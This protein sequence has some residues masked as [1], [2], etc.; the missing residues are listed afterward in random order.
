VI[1]ARKKM[2]S[3]WGEGAA[4]GEG[5]EVDGQRW[6]YGIVLLLLFLVVEI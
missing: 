6:T 4:R 5:A 1:A 2:A 3:V